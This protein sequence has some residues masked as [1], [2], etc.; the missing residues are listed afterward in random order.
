MLVLLQN[1]DVQNKLKWWFISSFKV[2]VMQQRII[3]VTI[4]MNTSVSLSVVNWH[5]DSQC[6]A[7]QQILISLTVIDMHATC[8]IVM[9]WWVF[10]HS[11]AQDVSN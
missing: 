8:V 2:N 5:L 4:Y 7:A 9:L 6:P 1:H 3:V 10:P 11:C